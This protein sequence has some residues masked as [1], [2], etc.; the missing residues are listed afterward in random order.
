MNPFALRAAWVCWALWTLGV[1][2]RW[3]DRCLPVAMARRAAGIRGTRN[4]H[5]P[6]FF[7][8]V[9]GHRPQDSGKQ[10]LDEWVFVVIAAA[11]GLLLTLLV[12][13]GAACSS[14]IVA[15]RRISQPNSTSGSWCSRPGDS[16]F[17]SSGDSV[18]SGCRFF[19]DY[20]RY[21]GARCFWQ[22]R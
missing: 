8:S 6:I 18:P 13:L 7:H 10:K 3:L 4:L 15:V 17:P 9:S 16:S 14:R 20:A 1:S 12:N 2:L 19:W 11:V 22:S 21:A 5:F